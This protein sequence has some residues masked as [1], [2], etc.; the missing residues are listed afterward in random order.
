MHPLVVFLAPSFGTTMANV[1]ST[2]YQYLCHAR[3]ASTQKSGGTAITSI[4]SS[5]TWVEESANF[6]LKPH[7]WI[8]I[9]FEVLSRRD[10]PNG[11]RFSGRVVHKKA[12]YR[13][14]VYMI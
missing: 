4:P 8:P 2:R 12:N 11:E 6:P 14:Q 1:G 10:I 13:T 5:R 9:S 3:L 7:I